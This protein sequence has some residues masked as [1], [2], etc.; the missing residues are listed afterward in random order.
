[1][2]KHFHLNMYLREKPEVVTKIDNFSAP[3]KHT[4][5]NIAQK[6]LNL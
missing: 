1:M 2:R 5:W 6:M 4:Q 3:N